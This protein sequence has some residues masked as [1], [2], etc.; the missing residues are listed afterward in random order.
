MNRSRVDLDLYLSTCIITWLIKKWADKYEAKLEALVE[1]LNINAYEPGCSAKGGTL[2]EQ[3]LSWNE[4]RDPYS[5]AMR[6]EMQ[7]NSRK[8]CERIELPG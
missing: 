7:N 8:F 2:K 3:D 6:K 4:D 5:N 1:G